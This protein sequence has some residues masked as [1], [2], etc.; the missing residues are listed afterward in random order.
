M[1]IHIT[2]HNVDVTPAL[3]TYATEK[4]ERLKKRGDSITTI[5]VIFDVEKVQQIAKATLHI[6]GADIHA[7]SE[8]ADMYSAIDLLIDKL[9][10][11]IT[12]HKEKIKDRRDH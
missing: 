2:G 5:N 10:H 8:S 3:R 9:D 1:Q 7:H 6:S 4:L 11:Q 12:K